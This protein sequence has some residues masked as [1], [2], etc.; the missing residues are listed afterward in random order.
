MDGDERLMKRRRGRTGSQ[1]V[2]LFHAEVFENTGLTGC[3]LSTSVPVKQVKGEPCRCLGGMLQ[4][5]EMARTKSPCR[6][7]LGK[8]RGPG[9]SHVAGIKLEKHK[10]LRDVDWPACGFQT[11]GGGPDAILTSASPHCWA[12]DSPRITASSYSSGSSVDAH[13][14]QVLAVPAGGAGAR[15]PIA[16]PDHI[17]T[18]LVPCAPA[19]SLADS[20]PAEGCPPFPEERSLLGLHVIFIQVR[21]GIN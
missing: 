13:G 7:T 10:S 14:S 2:L 19:P 5:E 17:L 8:F 9:G 21:V 3:Y 1:R 20:W 6:G 11:L 15:F 12:S 4:V 18:V 16:V